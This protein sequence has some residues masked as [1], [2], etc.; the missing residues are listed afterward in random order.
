MIYYYIKRYEYIKTN[1]VVLGGFQGVD[2]L[3]AFISFILERLG[4][5]K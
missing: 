1:Y 5:G 2:T 3:F 4:D